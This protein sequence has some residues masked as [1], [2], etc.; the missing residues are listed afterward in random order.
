MSRIDLGKGCSLRITYNSRGVLFDI[1]GGNDE[2]I[3][4]DI[5]PETAY[6]IAQA[7]VNSAAEHELA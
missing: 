2:V 3:C 4:T 6:K 7:L 1:T 5:L